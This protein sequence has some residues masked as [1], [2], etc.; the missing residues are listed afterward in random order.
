MNF[1][2]FEEEYFMLVGELCFGGEMVCYVYKV[3]KI[4]LGS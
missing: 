1:I 2:V 3:F 4:E